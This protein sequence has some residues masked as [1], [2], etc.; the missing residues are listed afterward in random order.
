VLFRIKGRKT[1]E[2]MKTKAEV[3][4]IG[5]MFATDD[6]AATT[7]LRLVLGVCFLRTR[8]AENAGQPASDRAPVEALAYAP[9]GQRAR[10][11]L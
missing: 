8:R 11:S 10:R 3:S 6:S 2:Q 9:H 1:S 5:E 4:M 7:V